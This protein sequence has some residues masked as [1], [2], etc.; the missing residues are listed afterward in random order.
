VIFFHSSSS[1]Q[2]LIKKEK[3]LKKILK[4]EQKMELLEKI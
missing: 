2:N 1:F 4:I 3:Y